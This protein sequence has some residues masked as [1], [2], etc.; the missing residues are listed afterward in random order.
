MGMF[1]CLPLV[2]FEGL[3]PPVV[4]TLVVEDSDGSHSDPVGTV[5]LF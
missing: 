1:P 5:S 2:E 3:P 4:E